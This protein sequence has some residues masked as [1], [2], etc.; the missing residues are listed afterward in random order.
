MLIGKGKCKEGGPGGTEGRHR[1]PSNLTWLPYMTEN[2]VATFVSTLDDTVG[3]SNPLREHA[4]FAREKTII[5]GGGDGEGDVG[6]IV[7]SAE[8]CGRVG[9]LAVPRQARRDAL[10]TLHHGP[11]RLQPAGRLSRWPLGGWGIPEPPERS[12]WTLLSD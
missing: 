10:S 2:V 12:N 5:R 7:H 6:G 3:F 4:A 1:H 9:L 11:A 8:L